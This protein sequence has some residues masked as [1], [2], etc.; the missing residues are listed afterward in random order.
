MRE[1]FTASTASKEPH[2]PDGSYPAGVRSAIAV[3]A[4]AGVPL[5]DAT[6]SRRSVV[7]VVF[8]VAAFVYFFSVMGTSEMAPA[9]AVVLDDAVSKTFTTP[10]CA[11]SR[12]VDARPLVRTTKG[13]A[14]KE[15]HVPEGDCWSNGGFFGRSS[16]RWEQLLD[17]LYLNRIGHASRWRPDGTWRW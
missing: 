12:P 4:P 16:S 3:P 9:N 7:S 1:D 2:S 15:G 17:R 13:M 14:E 6:V 5:N 8:A 10:A 11:S